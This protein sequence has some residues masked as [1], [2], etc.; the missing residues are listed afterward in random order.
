MDPKKDATGQAIWAAFNGKY[1]FEVVEREDDY[2]VGGTTEQYFTE[3]KD[4]LPHEK[5]AI[6]FAKGKI[7]D[8]GCGTG[9]HTLYL[10]SKGFDVV[11]ID[12]S[13]LAIKVCK[14]RG[15]KKAR[16]LSILEVDK[17]RPRRFDTIL[18]LGN[19]FGLLQN[20]KTAKRI[21]KKFTKFLLK[22]QL[23]L[24]KVVIHTKR[25]ILQMLNIGKEI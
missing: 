1:D 25:Q 17:F 14:K 13:P 24:Q 3:F 11:G 12:I 4:W 15:L 5:K 8:I 10:Q 19:N 21:L 6:R 20:R 23:L 18:L 2:I 7:L 9:K 22:K 16:V